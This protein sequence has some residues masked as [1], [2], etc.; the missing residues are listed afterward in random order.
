[1]GDPIDRVRLTHVQIPFKEPFGLADGAATLKDAVVVQL[2]TAGGL[3]AVGEASPGAGGADACWSALT[4]R[5]APSLPGRAV[6]SVDEIGQL[7]SAWADLDRPAAAGAET[8]LWD[9]LGQVRHQTL[10]GLLGAS[11]TRLM[12]GVESGLAVGLYPTIVDLLRGIEPHLDEG[13]RR[14]KLKIAPGRDVELVKAVRDHFGEDLPLMVDGQGA[15][16]RSDL[17]VFQRL[18]D[19]ALLM[20]EQPLPADDLDGLAEWQNRLLTP[21]CL[22]ET[23]ATPKATAQALDRGAGRIVNLKLQ[24]VGG[25][26]PARAIH[27]VCAARGVACWVGT[28]PELGIG[29]AGGIHLATL[30]DCRYPADIEPS[31]RW[32]VDDYVTPRLELVAPGRFAVPTRPGVGFQVD[33]VKLRRYAVREAAF[34]VE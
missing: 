26:G 6:E 14:V 32:F 18:E 19:F 27:D 9:L 5:I 8:A 7:A 29:Q 1:M 10:A 17:D 31:A 22:D 28:T 30:A 33:P 3:V 25:F 4:G 15:Y 12:A 13:Y 16:R 23:A 20:F 2:D 24:R 21:I 11:E 34:T